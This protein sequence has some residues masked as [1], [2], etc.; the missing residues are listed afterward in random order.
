MA[1]NTLSPQA[2]ATQFSEAAPKK[3]FCNSCFQDLKFKVHTRVNKDGLTNIDDAVPDRENQLVGLPEPPSKTH[4]D[5]I[6]CMPPQNPE[7]RKYSIFTAGSIEMGAAVQWQKLMVQH[8]S[9][10]PIT[11]CNPRRGN[12]DPT[13]IPKADDANFKSQVEWEL[14]ALERATVICFFFDVTTRSPVSLLELGLWASSKKIIVCC[15]ENYWRQGNVELVCG[16]YNIPMVREFRDLVPEVRKML[17]GRMELDANGDVIGPNVP[18]KDAHI[19][20]P[21]DFV[22]HPPVPSD[23]KGSK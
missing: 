13:D 10:L 7:F 20:S 2:P 14:D 21:M 23:W 22:D 16:R 12:W 18:D 5:F 11:V 6:H 15:N 8:L 17:K 4:R 19:T 1:S 3:K 9:D